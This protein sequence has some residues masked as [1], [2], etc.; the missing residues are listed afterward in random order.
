[1]A[2]AADHRFDIWDACIIAAAA[3]AGCRLLLS[4]DLADGLTWRGLTLAN[5]FAAKPHPLL[6]R[7]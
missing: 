4:E 1:M 6:R 2:L 3:D 7:L 5:P